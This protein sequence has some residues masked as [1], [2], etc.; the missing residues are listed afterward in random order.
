MR[1]QLW[2]LIVTSWVFS[3]VSFFSG[4][5]PYPRLLAST[6]AASLGLFALG[7]VCLRV[8]RKRRKTAK[9]V[10]VNDLVWSTHPALRSTRPAETSDASA[11]QPV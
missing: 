5:E 8:A 9:S 2:R 10:S 4:I 1:W 6:T 7:L 3:A 11:P